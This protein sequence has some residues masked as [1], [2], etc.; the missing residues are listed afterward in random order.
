[1]ALLYRA[2]G[3]SG[4][5]WLAPLR[6]AMPD[7]EIRLWP[8]IGDPAEIDGAIVWKPP[9][10]WLAT[11]PNL[12]II[13]SLGAGV[14]HILLDPD[15]PPGVP[16]IRL[17]DPAMAETMTEWIVMQVLRLHRQDLDYAA[18]QREGVW[19]QLDQ[20]TARERRIGLLG[21]GALGAHAAQTLRSIGFDVA[22]WSRSRKSVPGIASFAGLEELESF[23]ARTD[24]LVLLL[25]LTADT[26]GLLDAA[27]LAQLP[28]GAGIVNAA[29]GR[30]IVDE[31]LLDALGSGQIS[32]AALDVFRH[33]P[34]PPEHPFWSHPSVIVSPHV[35][36]ATDPRSA[37]VIIGDTM[38]RLRSGGDLINRVTPTAGY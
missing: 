23:L 9:A 4:T 27:R 31:A 38:R 14:D 19:R 22:G 15:L 29:R 18:Q 7:E 37:A 35:A 25:P 30:H 33:E 11:L 28:R 17:V 3:D 2:S 8:E 1:M 21:M 16:I 32:A 13:L 24:I 20:P 26:D 36:A 6:A 12:K 34:L 5:E 10:G